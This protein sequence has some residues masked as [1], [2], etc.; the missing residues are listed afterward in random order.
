MEEEKPDIIDEAKRTDKNPK[1]PASSVTLVTFPEKV[2]DALSTS[3]I[4]HKIAQF[5]YC[6]LKKNFL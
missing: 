3:Y 2:I 6:P 5:K 4:L 1:V